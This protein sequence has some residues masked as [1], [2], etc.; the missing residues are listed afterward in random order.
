MGRNPIKNT[1]VVE[2][3]EKIGLQEKLTEKF[4]A[5]IEKAKRKREEEAAEVSIQSFMSVYNRAV[6]YIHISCIYP[7]FAHSS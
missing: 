3:K 6:L 4:N 2:G 1:K 5:I 7:L